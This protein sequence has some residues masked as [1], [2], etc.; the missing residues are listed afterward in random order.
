MG[1]L[2]KLVAARRTEDRVCGC[3]AHGLR[4]EGVKLTLGFN[5]LQPLEGVDDVVCV[6]NCCS[7]LSDILRRFEWTSRSS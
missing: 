7:K 2:L 5:K 3:E 4:I 6:E 1:V